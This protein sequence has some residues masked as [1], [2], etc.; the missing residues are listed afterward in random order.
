MQPGHPFSR[1]C[2]HIATAGV[3]SCTAGVHTSACTPRH[4][5][6]GVCASMYSYMHGMQHAPLSCQAAAAGIWL[7]KASHLCQPM[8]SRRAHLCMP[9]YISNCNMHLLLAGLHPATAA[10][11][12]LRKVSQLLSAHARQACIPRHECQLIFFPCNM[13]PAAP[14]GIF[15]CTHH[16]LP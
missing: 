4:A 1:S 2:K 5:H 14:A 10:K 11:I 6:H 7:R 8:H 16:T 3:C 13:H 9:E 12:L 15:F